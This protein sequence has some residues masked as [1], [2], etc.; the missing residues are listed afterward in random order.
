VEKLNKSAK[1]MG[2]G[3]AILFTQTKRNSRVRLYILLF[4][5]FI[6]SDNF[7][8]SAKPFAYSRAFCRKN[9]R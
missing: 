8:V 6:V 5:N 3:N 4:Y 7:Y 1:K 9:S 2:V